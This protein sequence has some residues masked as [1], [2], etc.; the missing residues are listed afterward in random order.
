MTC[1][2]QRI[3]TCNRI[4]IK[5]RQQSQLRAYK[6]R[7]ETLERQLVTSAVTAASAADHE[8]KAMQTVQ[9]QVNVLKQERDDYKAAAAAAAENFKQQLVDVRIKHED[10]ISKL[11]RVHCVKT[12][13][14]I[15]HDMFQMLHMLELT[16]ILVQAG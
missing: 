11:M 8:L 1:D 13:L 16:H 14:F 3:V 12:S 9:Q 2:A 6:S 15:C 4:L 7:V 5:L 10:F